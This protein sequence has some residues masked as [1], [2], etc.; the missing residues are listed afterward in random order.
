MNLIRDELENAS[1]TSQR[2][3]QTRRVRITAASVGL[4]AILILIWR[5]C[6]GPSSAEGEGNVVVSVQVAK[7]DV[8]PIANEITTVA[9]LSAAR[10]ATITPKISAQ[11]ARMDLLTNRT[12]H[13]GDVLAVLES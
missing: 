6:R 1:D 2:W 10:E 13:A 9:T 5:S 3:W 4:L 12:V 8:G 11:I 7:A